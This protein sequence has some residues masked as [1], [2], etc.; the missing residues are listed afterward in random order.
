MLKIGDRV[1]IVC[2]VAALQEIIP[3]SYWLSENP[4]YVGLCGTIIGL[5][6][7]G[8][9]VMCDGYCCFIFV[10]EKHLQLVVSPQLEL[11]F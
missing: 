10:D 8:V 5:D 7:D 3:V 6:F 4:H 11:E 2:E 9:H 1:K